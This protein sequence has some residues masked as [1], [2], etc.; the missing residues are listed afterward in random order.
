LPLHSVHNRISRL[1]NTTPRGEKESQLPSYVV[2]KDTHGVPGLLTDGKLDLT[3]RCNNSCRHCW[4]KSSSCCDRKSVEMSFDEVISVLD[5]GRKLGCSRWA[6]S[7]GEPMIREDFSEIFEHLTQL[8][9]SYSLNTNG[10]LI[11]PKIA[12]LMTKKGTKMVSLYGATAATHDYITRTPGSFEAAIHGMKYLNEAGAGFI[13]QIVPMKANYHELDA[14]KALAMEL[15]IY[16]KFGASWLYLSAYGD[17]AQNREII[18]QRLDPAVAVE[19]ANPRPETTGPDDESAGHTPTECSDDTLFNS[20]VCRGSSFHVDPYGFASHCSF[21]RDPELRYDLRKGSLRDYIE[22]VH[23]ALA[24]RIRGGEEYLEN[25]GECSLRED[26]KWCPAY[27]CL[28]HGRYSARVDYL[29]EL[30]KETRRAK[31]LWLQHHRRYYNL[32][33]TTVQVDSDLPIEDATFHRTV[34]LFEIN[35]PGDD[36]VRIRHHFGRCRGWEATAPPIYNNPPWMIYEYKDHLIYVEGANIEGTDEDEFRNGRRTAVFS[37]DY[38]EIDVYNSNMRDKRKYKEGNL[39]CLTMFPN[40]Q[41]VFAPILADRNACYLHACG[42]NMDGQGILFAGHSGAGKSTMAI[43]L[44]EHA[45]NLCDERIVVKR[46]DEGFSIHGSWSH[47]QVKEVSH[48]SVPLRAVCFLNQYP[49]SSLEPI[50]DKS[51]IIQRLLPRV[52]KPLETREWWEKTL[53]LL[54][55][56]VCE[57]PCYVLN[58]DMS[59]DVVNVLKGLVKKEDHES[60]ES[61]CSVQGRR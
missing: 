18:G 29:C 14:M 33:G 37:S 57:I 48:S 40:D 30:A 31:N 4:I 19:L 15:S 43:L 6:L 9:S 25:C 61:I 53:V 28:E 58:F 27:A 24:C 35:K 12:R 17:E 2:L 26:C 45:T 52:V 1:V 50:L 42:V 44:K 54:D 55:A 8:P 56:L 46:S 49:S 34:R 41:V 39:D 38:T 11:T 22:N 21:I 7:G 3:Y 23:T 10:T 32:A 47:G 51:Q 13:V 60:E 36:I 16:W 20:C 59:G 5:E